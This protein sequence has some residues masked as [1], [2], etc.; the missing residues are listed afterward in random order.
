MKIVNTEEFRNTIQNGTTLVDFFA[1]WCGPCKML[2]PVVESVSTQ[3]SDINFIKVNVDDNMDLAQE[4]GIMSIPQMFIF[5]DGQVI[6]KTGGYM[7]E[8]GV[9]HF[10]DDATK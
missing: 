2:G 8:A 5:K 6:A 3:Y 4:F 1:D 10:I 9:K 7:D